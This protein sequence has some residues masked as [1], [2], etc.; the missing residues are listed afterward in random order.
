PVQA[1]LIVNSDVQS[2]IASDHAWIEGCSVRGPLIL[3]GFNAIVG[4]DVVEP[5]S[6]PQGAC[7]DISA[8]ISRKG[9]KVW[10]LRYYGIDDTFKHSAA[11]GGTFCGRPLQK[12]LG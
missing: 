11:E 4:V 9:E 1:S 6:L 3:E 12:W 10:F 5:L 2:E 7:L 8:G